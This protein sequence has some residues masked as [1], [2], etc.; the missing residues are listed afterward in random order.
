MPEPLR[1]LHEL[2]QAM[3]EIFANQ[4]HFRTEETK[5]SLPV[6]RYKSLLSH[7]NCYYYY[8][9]IVIWIFYMGIKL[10]EN[11]LSRVFHFAIF[12]QS[13]QT[14]CSLKTPVLKIPNNGVFTRTSCRRKKWRIAGLPFLWCC[15]WHFVSNSTTT[16]T[17]HVGR[18]SRVFEQ[19]TEYKQRCYNNTRRLSTI[20]VKKMDHALE[21][22]HFVQVYST[23]TLLLT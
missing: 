2:E 4:R 18:S 21:E 15:Q 17:K 14:H 9:S 19:F 3:C 6:K 23:F 7:V 11:L 5:W 10:R 12:L 13:W 1:K 8:M 16:N 20:L 22:G